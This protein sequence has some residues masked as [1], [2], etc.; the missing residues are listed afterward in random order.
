MKNTNTNKYKHSSLVCILLST[1]MLALPGQAQ[2]YV[3]DPGWPKPL[4]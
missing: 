4:P 3:L 2:D 1:L